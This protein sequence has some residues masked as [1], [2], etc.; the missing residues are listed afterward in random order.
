M[1]YV[2]R[3]VPERENILIRAKFSVWDNNIFMILA[4][5]ISFFIVYYY[6]ADLG[7]LFSLMIVLFSFLVS[8][9]IIFFDDVLRE[10]VVTKER[11]V[12]KVGVFRRETYDLRMNRIVSVSID[13]SFSGMFLGYAAIIIHG[14]GQ[15][16]HR[17]RGV[18]NYEQVRDEID[19]Y[20]RR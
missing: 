14:F 16:K 2:D 20:L 4:P 15:E 12:G 17:I 1:G 10:L 6:Y 3:L 18:E 5:L 7:F 8:Y 9:S 13:Q 19:K 11:V